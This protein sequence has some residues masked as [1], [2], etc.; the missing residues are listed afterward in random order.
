MSEN[1]LRDIPDYEH[2][3]D[4][5]YPSLPPPSSP[6][7]N[8]FEE[9]LFGNA[10][11][12]DGEV[13]KLAEVPMPKR[14]SVKRPQPKLDSNRLISE[15]GLPALRTL[16]D[17]VTFKGKGHEAEDLKLLL[18]KMEN[19]AHR[20]YPKLQF[21][22][23]IEKVE[24]LGGKKEVQT[25]LKRIRMDM[26]LTHEDFVE[27]AQAPAQEE[28][29]LGEDASFHEDPFVHST[30]APLS[31]TEEQQRRIELNKQLALERRLARQKLASSQNLTLD[32]ADE[33]STSSSGLHISQ[34]NPGV[35]Q[36]TSNETPLKQKPTKPPSSPLYDN[37]CA[38]PVPKGIDD[39]SN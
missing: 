22:D 23:F 2:T 39:D 15:K 16:F 36:S 20:L 8:D 33:P 14:R 25:C 9:G 4:E 6:G 3:V 38:S 1:S 32:E 19:W 17:N 12:E 31:L 34:E 18:K 37:E 29:D 5:I 21:E 10:E 30:P 7:Q 13:S 26:P 27:E 28:F 35:E 24:S 11:G